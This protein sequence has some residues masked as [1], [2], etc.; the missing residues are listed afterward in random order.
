M[1]T[2]REFMDAIAAGA[3]G[4]AISSTAKSYGQILGSS[5][6]LNFAIM[7]LRWRGYAHIYQH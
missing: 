6:R 3:A 5:D 4:M 7:G 1:V 2:R